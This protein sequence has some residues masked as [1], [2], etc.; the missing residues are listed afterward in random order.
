[1]ADRNRSGESGSKL[2]AL[3]ALRE[4]SLQFFWFPEG[5]EDPDT[6]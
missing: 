3:H 4:V 6:A 2:H 1:M 5:G